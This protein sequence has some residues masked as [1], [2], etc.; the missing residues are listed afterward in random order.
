MTEPR[1]AVGKVGDIGQSMAQCPV[2]RVLELDGT[3]PS[4]TGTRVPR[5]PP[6][7]G[8]LG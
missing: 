4:Y 8:C 3:V 2:T 7:I 5:R 1:P 6:S